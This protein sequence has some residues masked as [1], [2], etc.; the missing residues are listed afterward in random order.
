MIIK[1]SSENQ[2]NLEQ[3][4]D[5]KTLGLVLKKARQNSMEINYL[6]I[7]IEIIR[8]EYQTKIYR[9]DRLY[10]PLFIEKSSKDLSKFVQ[11]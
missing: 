11:I 6:D 9:K 5:D 4:F 3:L 2:Q 8:G 7:K 10:V 1:E